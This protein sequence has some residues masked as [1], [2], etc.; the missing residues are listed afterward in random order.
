[1]PIAQTA[2]PLTVA[3]PLGENVVVVRDFHGEERISG[4]FHYSL[5][6]VSEDAGLA[7]D[8]VVGQGMTVSLAM[9]DGSQR[10]FH[11]I[12]TRFA[13]GGGYH[14]T[15][16]YHAELRPWLWLLTLTADCRI[17]QSQTVPQIV[18]ALFG[19]LGFTDYRN[20]LTG[21]YAARDYCVQYRETAFAFVSR[22]LEEEG[23]FYFFEHA[24]GAHTL[25]L[26]DDAD[27]HAPCPGLAAAKFRQTATL[28]EME[29]VVTRCTLERQVTTGKV[30]LDDF[31]FE[32]PATDLV[33][34]VEGSAG[35]L[36]VY[37]YPGGFA[38]T[39]D[40]ERIAKL[41][42][43][44]CEVPAN[45]LRGDSFCRA[46][47]AGY[48]FDLEGHEREDANTTYVL[49]SVSVSA[50]QEV[51][52]NSFEAFPAD[53]PFRPARGTPR[54]TI[55]GA[56]TAV[57]VGKSGEEIWTDSFGR[58][59][60]Q[61]H[62]DQKGQADENSSCWVRVAQGW[63][64]QGWGSFFLPRIGQ[65]VVVSFLEGDPDRPLV[66]GCVYNAQTTVPYTLPDHQTRSTLKGKSSKA[67]EESNELRFEDKK[68]SEEVYLRAAKD[69]VVSVKNARTTTV[70]E[71]DDTLT[72]SKG[73]RSV[74]VSEGDEELLVSKGKRTVT[75]TEGDEAHTVTQGKRDV[76]V[77]GDETHRNDAA[78]THETG[79]NYTLKVTG[80][81][82][83]EATGAIT[84]K[85]GGALAIE[86][87]ADLSLEAATALKA[88]AGTE[89]SNEA[90]TSLKNKAGLDLTIEGLSIKEKASTTVAIEAGA[91]FE[92]KGSAMGTL[93]GGGMLNVKG[94]LVK[95]N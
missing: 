46:F 9:A 13:Q 55:A 45:T 7:F 76:K 23:I 26:A 37:D 77:G 86:S 87:G 27:A 24:E 60:V 52:T 21:T 12:V 16:V 57:V 88:K 28:A 79:G 78:F 43:E 50:N 85:S 17:F 3:S 68:D 2:L 89:L 53:V 29:D 61:F 95:I 72:V 62:W 54:P 84:L 70:E 11:G 69:L 8:D 56:Q 31:N 58:V 91:T 4:L 71:A 44:A 41:R 65:E 19:E 36:R 63:A 10:H 40:G 38:Q 59:K 42:I 6:M 92:V 1:M 90:G 83:I 25:V 15:T 47:T 48:S 75:V 34:T 64:G 49:R 94:G 18:E 67:G 33:V 20:A 74:T 32:T 5:S 66:T 22:L 35:E 80:D 14:R 81:L 51:Y 30:A 39:S 82:V 73:K 93:D